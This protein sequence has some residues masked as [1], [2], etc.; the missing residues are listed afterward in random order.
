MPVAQR[1]NTRPNIVFIMSDDHAS[2]ANSCYGSTINRTPNIDRIAAGGARLTNC[3][4]TN[5]IC[6][7]SRAAILTGQ[8]SHKNGV[9]T[10][11]DRLDP[12]RDNVAKRLQQAGYQTAMIGNWHLESDPAGFDY[13][14]I[15][16]GQGAYYD[17]VLIEHGQKKQHKGYCTD[18]IGDLTLQ[19]LEG[20]DKD[21]AIFC[22]VPP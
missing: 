4:C 20:R 18:I 5:S 3:F 6:T 19:W 22:H 2:H 7:P 9:Y 13:W 8:Y 15:L 14:N 1:A 16:P 12:K 10:L 11:A 21:E 17:P